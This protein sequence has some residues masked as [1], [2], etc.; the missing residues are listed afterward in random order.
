MATHPV[1]I[2][3]SPASPIKGDTSAQTYAGCREEVLKPAEQYQVL[4]IWA[5]IAE[6]AAVAPADEKSR[7]ELVLAWQD[8]HHRQGPQ[9]WY[10]NF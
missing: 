10:P 2:S 4:V 7:V 5:A 1:P 6:A 8:H 9:P 3:I